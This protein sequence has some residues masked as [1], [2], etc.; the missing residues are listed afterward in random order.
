MISRKTWSCINNLL[1]R[2]K[3]N[4]VARSF[5]YNGEFISNPVDIANKFNDYFQNVAM[6]LVDRLPKLRLPFQEYLA[7]S[8]P[9]SIFFYPT[10]P[11]KIKQIINNSSPKTSASWDEIPSVVVKHLPDN[12]IIALTNIFNVSLSQGKFLFAFKGS[13]HSQKR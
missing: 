4:G 13:T 6:N 8:N 12:V 10:T 9:S 11:Y 1:G 5:S 3:L 2:T 7:S